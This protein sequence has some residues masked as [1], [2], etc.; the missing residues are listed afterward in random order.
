[1][2]SQQSR[3]SPSLA[4]VPWLVDWGALAA[5]AEDSASGPADQVGLLASSRGRHLHNALYLHTCSSS[6]LPEP[7]PG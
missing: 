4:M 7:R 3:G 5:A 6:D 2:Q 1:M